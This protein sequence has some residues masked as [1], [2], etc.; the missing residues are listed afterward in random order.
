MQ[1][2]NEWIKARKAEFSSCISGFSSAD[3]PPCPG[4]LLGALG[5][6]RALLERRGWLQLLSELTQFIMAVPST[7]PTLCQA[8]P[9]PHA[10][11]AE[12]MTCVPS[13]VILALSGS[14]R[15]S[16]ISHCPEAKP[17]QR[18]EKKPFLYHLHQH[19]LPQTGVEQ[20]LKNSEGEKGG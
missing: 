2:I 4:V 9:S 1:G 16:G 11:S 8:F 18:W 19:T 3:C 13:T 6:G 10:G 15:G 20:K 17:D 14:A 12:V 7:A 5:W